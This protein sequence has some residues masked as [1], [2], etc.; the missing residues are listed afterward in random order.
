MSAKRILILDELDVKP[1]MSGAVRKAYLEGYRPG[2]ENRGM[3]LVSA[4]QHPPAI[5]IVE[6]A[7]TQFYLWSVE[8]EAGWWKQRLS[9]KPDGSDE[10]TDKEAF[11]QSLDRMLLGRK[12]RTLTDMPGGK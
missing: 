7:G 8:G 2:A 3:K 1:G 5:D 12:R 9:R 4:W 11:W 10:R 6:L